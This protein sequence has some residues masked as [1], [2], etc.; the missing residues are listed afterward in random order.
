VENDY[1]KILA[2]LRFHLIK[3][4][5]AKDFDVKIEN[6]DMKIIAMQAA[7]A[8]FA[9]YGMMNLPE[10]MVENYANDML[11]NKD[12]AR[13]L[14]DRA[15]ENKIIDVLKT[16]LGVEEKVISLDEFRKFFEKEEDKTEETEA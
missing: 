12:N 11:K 10:E 15:M 3:E 4:Q 9:Q 7:R 6:E 8:Q 1:P 2:D 16:K 13:N 5:I 14:L